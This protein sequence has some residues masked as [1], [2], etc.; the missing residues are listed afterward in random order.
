MVAS[1]VATVLIRFW[2]PVRNAMWM[3]PHPSQPKNPASLTGPT[4]SRAWPRLM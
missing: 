4:W 3:K 1:Q 2:T